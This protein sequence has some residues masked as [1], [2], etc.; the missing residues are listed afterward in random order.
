MIASIHIELTISTQDR[1]ITYFGDDSMIPT[2][3]VLHFRRTKWEMLTRGINT[4]PTLHVDK[5]FETRSRKG[6]T[7][8]RVRWKGRDSIYD[9]WIPIVY[10]QKYGITAEPILCDPVQ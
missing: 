6:S 5:T 4:C 10:L 7:E 2:K 9:S 3:V 8:M 1:P